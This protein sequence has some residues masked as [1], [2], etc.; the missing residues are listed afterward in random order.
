MGLKLLKIF[1]A[2]EP[3][4]SPNGGDMRC[5]HLRRQHPLNQIAGG[6]IPHNRKHELTLVRKFI[7]AASLAPRQHLHALRYEGL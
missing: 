2:S 3:P 5:R 7:I 6:D 1:C 4:G